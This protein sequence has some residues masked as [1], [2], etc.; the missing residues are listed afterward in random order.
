MTTTPVRHSGLDRFFDSLGR[1]PVRRST[2]DRHIGGVCGGLA[3]STG[4]PPTVVRLLAIVL[5]VS[6]VGVPAYLVAWLLLPAD[7]GRI[8]LQRALRAG[9]GSSVALLVITVLSVWPSPLDDRHGGWVLAAAA[10]AALI[11]LGRRRT[12]RPVPP[13]IQPPFPHP[14]PP[15][16]HSPRPPAPGTPQDA[17]R[18]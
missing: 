1:L 10:I 5:G 12:G 13:T 6:G 16:G 9:A 17:P 15:Q 8:H 14:Y 11:V 18:S 2:I 4:L 7:D 3:R